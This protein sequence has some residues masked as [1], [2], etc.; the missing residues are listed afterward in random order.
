MVPFASGFHDY[1]VYKLFLF[2]A[3][4]AV[5]L[6][7]LTLKHMEFYKLGLGILAQSLV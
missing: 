2:S 5:F 4:L 1:S 3:S 6:F 7:A